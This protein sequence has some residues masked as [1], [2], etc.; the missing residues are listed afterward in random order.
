MQGEGSIRAI[1]CRVLL[2][3]SFLLS[4]S[5]ATMFPFDYYVLRTGPV[6]I[7]LEW[8]EIRCPDVIETARREKE[9]WLLLPP[10]LDVPDYRDKVVV[11]R[12]DGKRVEVFAEVVDS[13]GQVYPLPT[14][15]TRAMIDSRPRDGFYMR[16]T[17]PK[18][19]STL[20]LAAVR[21]RSSYPITL[22]EV[23]WIDTRRPGPRGFGLD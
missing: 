1:L 22:S 8:T 4:A 17:S 14:W 15:M 9:L 21:L 3:A 20:R 2:G 6:P 16:L 12:K 7:G 13:E 19:P 18:L 11:F 10:P 5:C 23:L